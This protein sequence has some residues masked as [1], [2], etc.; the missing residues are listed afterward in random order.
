MLDCRLHSGAAVAVVIAC[1]Q[2][3]TYFNCLIVVSTRDN[4][5]ILPRLVVNNDVVTCLRSFHT[6]ATGVFWNRPLCHG[7]T[8][9]PRGEQ[10]AYQSK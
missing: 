3:L 1:I 4:N 8:S 2:A 7:Y 9:L 10:F 6:E 5:L